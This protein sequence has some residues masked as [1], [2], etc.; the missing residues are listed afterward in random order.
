MHQQLSFLTKVMHGEQE[1]YVLHCKL[2]SGLFLFPK[3]DFWTTVAIMINT[4]VFVLSL[5]FVGCVHPAM[6]RVLSR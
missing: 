3:A 1:L 6:Q 2:A 5:N 4:S